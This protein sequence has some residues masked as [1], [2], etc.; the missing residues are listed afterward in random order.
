MMPVYRDFIK[1]HFEKNED[2]VYLIS[3]ADK[4]LKSIL[5]NI[6]IQKNCQL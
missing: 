2:H 3:A 4:K 1:K 5:K 6:L